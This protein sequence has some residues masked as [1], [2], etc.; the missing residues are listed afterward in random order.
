M[1]TTEQTWQ[2]VSD[3]GVCDTS[4]G[5]KYMRNS[6]GKLPTLKACQTACQ[7]DV[8][9]QSI[10]YYKSG[11]CSFFSSE[12]WRNR[13]SGDDRSSCW[14]ITFAFCAGSVFVSLLGCAAAHGMMTF[15]KPR[16]AC[17]PTS[18][19]APS[20]S[21]CLACS[22]TLLRR[23]DGAVAPFNNWSWHPNKGSDAKTDV[24]MPLKTGEPISE[25]V[26]ITRV[27]REP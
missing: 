11:W 19:P 7:D 5:E 3:N 23:V 4:A 26:S 6:P 1:I 21:G 16:N 27:S 8:E 24:H 17:V 13:N 22:D 9:C 12:W 14:L 15:P 10:T 2:Q 20:R 25:N 18:A